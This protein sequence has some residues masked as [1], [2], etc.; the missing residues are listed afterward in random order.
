[1][2]KKIEAAIEKSKKRKPNRQ[3]A[4]KSDGSCREEEK[5]RRKEETNQKVGSSL[6]V[7]I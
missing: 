5:E 2:K 1:L 3:R 7:I 6:D 4:V